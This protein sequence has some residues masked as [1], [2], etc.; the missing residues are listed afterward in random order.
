MGLEQKRD[1]PYEEAIT[2]WFDTVYSPVVD[3]IR[4]EDILRDFPGRTEADLYLWI[5]KH[6]A[7][8]GK[9]LGWE[10]G[11]E[12]A[13]RDYAAHFSPKPER[14]LAR[15][16][17]RILS[18]MRPPDLK[19]AQA[20]EEARRLRIAAGDLEGLFAD[21]LIAV[22]AD[23]TQW[24]GLDQAL[25]LAKLEKCRL[26]GL[27][28]VESKSQL[29][30]EDT[31]K[32]V[33]S[34]NRR[35][36]EAGVPGRLA[37]EAGDAAETICKRARWTDLVVVDY[38]CAAKSAGSIGRKLR[39]IIHRGSRPVLVV[40]RPAAPFKRLFL[41]YDGSPKS[42][43]AL[44]VATH[45]A[46]THDIPIYVIVM[47]GAKGTSASEMQ[48]RIREYLGNHGVDGDVAEVDTGSTII[49]NLLSAIELQNS[50]L[51]ILGARSSLPDGV[52]EALISTCDRCI[53]ICR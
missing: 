2:H 40:P 17:E 32:M 38:D 37:I 34:F 21:M 23:S 46:D 35:C 49:S 9:A 11:T 47:A 44:F 30:S 51:I 39:T 50:D 29:E 43:E 14:L 15:V 24:R 25:L 31:R 45:L 33:V 3:I 1:I 6:R 12:K 18:V 20:A 10:I 5:S 26:H 8:V 27:H 7:E 53:L 28:V 22:G 4:E 48:R 52:L 13:V 36:I 16:G 42:E 19:P 41:A